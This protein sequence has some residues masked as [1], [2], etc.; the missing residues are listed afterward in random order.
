ML[1]RNITANNNSEEVI[2]LNYDVSY[3][4]PGWH[5][6]AAVFNSNNQ[7]SLYIDGNVATSTNVGSLSTIYRVYNSKNN[8]NLVIGTASF[9]KQTLAQ[10]TNETTDIYRYNGKIADVRFYGQALQQSDIKAL[11][12]RFLL[13]SFTNLKWSTPTGERY[14]IEQIERFFL[15]RLPGAKSNMFNVKIKNSNITD[16]GLRSNI[17]KNIIAALSKTIPTHT[18]LKSIIWE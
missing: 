2:N 14:Y 11:Q 18:K 4:T 6:F 3:L 17:E 5:H 13:N 15:H 7:L 16:L 10:Y 8:P 1:S 12:K 9:K